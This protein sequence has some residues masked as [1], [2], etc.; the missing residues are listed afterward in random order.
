[1]ALN[2]KELGFRCGIEAHQQLEGLKLFCSCPT[3]NSR[4]GE[5]IKVERKLR[6]VI[7][8]TGE[9]DKAAAFEMSKGKK[10]NYIGNRKEACLVELDEEPPHE[11]NK[12]AVETALVIANLLNAKV[13]DEI[14]VMRKTVVDGSN[15]T[16]FQRTALVAYDGYIETSKGKVRIPTICL[17][18]EACQKVSEDKDSITYRLDRLGIPLIEIATEP[19]IVD[20]EHAKETA[21]KLGMI[22]RSTGKVKRGIGTIRQDVNVSIKGSSRVEIKG[23]QEL[24]L[25]PKVV[26]TEVKRLMGLKE[27]NKPEVRKFNPDGTT[28]FLRPM[29]GAARMYP[30][31]DVVPLMPEEAEVDVELIEDRIKKI[32]K[33]GIGK[34]L[35]G[36]SVKQHKDK[37][38]LDSA[39]KYKKI[40]P[41]FIAETV[42]TSP[43]QV[44]NQFNVDINPTEEDFTIIFDE[45]EKDKIAKESV[46][47]ILKENKPVKD[48][49]SKY[50]LMSD[51]ELEKELKKI[52][53][54]NKG[55]PFNALI[56]KAMGKLR[57]KAS[58]KKIAEALKKI[59]K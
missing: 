9:V 18:E 53:S 7:G 3:T 36:F 45:L 54:E 51:A 57:G 23:F 8:E 5:D 39:K 46:L 32:E 27:K 28:E 58:G 2:Y 15:T 48:V 4:K 11:I 26:E 47:E 56:G 40:K 22:L 33:L 6:A 24:K 1:M 13:V 50:E 14:Q 10:I 16:G 59:A 17:E 49:I 42:C 31:T 19:D 34:D 37:L 21:E 30:E 35:A 38:I 55:M 29:P 41:T 20:N 12:E 43:K 52:V 44:K 25:I